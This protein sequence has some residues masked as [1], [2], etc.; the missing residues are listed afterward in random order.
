[1]LRSILAAAALFGAVAPVSAATYTI[2]L[3]GN[4][5]NNGVSAP[6]RTLAKAVSVLKD[7]D[8]IVLRAGTYDGDV[9]ISRAAVTISSYPGE[10]AAISTPLKG[11][12]SN[13]LTLAPGAI[14]AHLSRLNVLGGTYYALKI[15]GDKRDK[16]TLIEDCVL[17]QSGHDC[18]KI[19]PG[20][21][22]ITFRRCEIGVSG[23][24]D[25][26]NAEGI[27]N[28]CADNMVVQDC[29]IHDIA[30]NGIYP[31]GG[32]RNALVERTR[33]ENCG[34]GGVM[35]GFYTD[36]QWF[37]QVENP[38]LFESLNGM[39]RNCVIV[40]TQGAGVGLYSA[41]DA[42][43][44]NNTMINVAQTL[45]AGILLNVGTQGTPCENVSVIN[46]IITQ[47]ATATRP[48]FESRDPNA[49]GLNFSNNRYWR[50]G[51]SAAFVNGSW[52]GGLANWQALG[53][54]P[55]STEGDPLLGANL[56][57]LAGS[58][59]IGTGLLLSDVTGDFTGALRLSAPDLGAYQTTPVS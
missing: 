33:I 38:R 22:G 51:G 46:N 52:T 9:S 6:F 55:A 48:M 8:S 57:P 53:M 14:G 10:T 36:L 43:V 40:N 19:T 59:C 49:T 13:T 29:W 23:L 1:M 47:N 5:K 11:K 3:T 39:V 27:D 4:D 45:H 7:G 26:S 2:S 30:T 21:D 16:A 44:Y 42:H 32:A 20:A 37:D 41:Q 50:Q 24:K 12:A 15:D 56:V 28:V 54:D 18:V 31:K 34:G 17:G 25:S 35:L 58:P